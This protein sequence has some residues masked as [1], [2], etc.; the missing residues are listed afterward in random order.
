MI[1]T[2]GRVVHV[3]QDPEVPCRAAI[4]NGVDYGRGKP[5]TITGTVFS[6]HWNTQPVSLI[7]IDP[8]HWHDPRLCPAIVSVPG[9]RK[10]SEG[11]TPMGNDPLAISPLRNEPELLGQDAE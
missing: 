5:V 7:T 4:I 2:V 9:V 11:A 8:D 3:Q 1:P 10:S 6:P